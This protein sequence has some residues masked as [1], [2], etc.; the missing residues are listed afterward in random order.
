MA[1]RTIRKVNPDLRRSLTAGT[2]G[3]Q[4]AQQQTGLVVTALARAVAGMHIRVCI[5]KT[6]GNRAP[7]RRLAE[8]GA[9]GVFTREIDS[10]MAHMCANCTRRANWGQRIGDWEEKAGS[11]LF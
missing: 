3:S 4:L 7:T 11:L 9:S 8:F 10:A 1:D 2:R 6:A 5:I